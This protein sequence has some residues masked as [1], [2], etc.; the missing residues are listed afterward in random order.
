LNRELSE[1]T[2][3]WGDDLCLD[4]SALLTGRKIEVFGFCDFAIGNKNNLIRGDS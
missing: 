4:K 3:I 2:R 1:L